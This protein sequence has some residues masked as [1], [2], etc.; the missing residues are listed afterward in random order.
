MDITS[1]MMEAVEAGPVVAPHPPPAPDPAC[2]PMLHV[3]APALH[4]LDAPH[5]RAALAFAQRQRYHALTCN[6]IAFA[7]F[8]VRVL[9]GGAVR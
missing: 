6:C 2:L 8:V 4:A 5:V 3:A 1:N 9:T 7:D